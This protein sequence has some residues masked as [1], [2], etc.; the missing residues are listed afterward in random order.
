MTDYESI[1][2]ITALSILALVAVCRCEPWRDT[3][4]DAKHLHGD[5]TQ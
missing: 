2:L 3:E 4:I 5:D 1:I